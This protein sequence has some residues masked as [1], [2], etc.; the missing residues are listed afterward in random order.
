M[1]QA[2]SKRFTA[3]GAIDAAG[4]AA[5]VSSVTVET[6]GTNA[7]TVAIKEGGSAGTIVWQGQCAGADRS[8]HFAFP[9]SIYVG[10]EAYVDLTGTGAAC[11]ISFEPPSP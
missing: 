1:R 7:A 6:D 2:R 3:D 8:Q 4:K 5:I 9:A 11:S 10:A